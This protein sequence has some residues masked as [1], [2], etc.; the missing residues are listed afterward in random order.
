MQLVLENQF[1]ILQ[2]LK[3]MN[4]PRISTD[5]KSYLSTQI[6]KTIDLLDELRSVG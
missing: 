1:V 2:T 3:A 4:E 5:E 6:E